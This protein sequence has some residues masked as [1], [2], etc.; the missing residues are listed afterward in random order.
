MSS[1]LQCVETNGGALDPQLAKA[2]VPFKSSITAKEF[3][4]RLSTQA[5]AVTALK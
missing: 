4:S 3:L 1:F 5:P 2:I